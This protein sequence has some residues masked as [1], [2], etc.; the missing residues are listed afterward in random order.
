MKSPMCIVLLN[1][2]FLAAVLSSAAAA[3]QAP[4]KMRI[5]GE[6]LVLAGTQPGKLMFADVVPGS[7]VI[8]S[9][10]Q[11]GKDV[12][13]YEQGRDYVVNYALGTI[14]R[15][16]ASRMPD[17]S[18]NMLYGQKNFD[19]SKFPGFGNHAF[20]V[21]VDYE[22]R[23]GR[24]LATPMDQSPLLVKTRAKLSAGGPFKLIA[25][26]D[27]ISTGC[28]ASTED[29][30]FQHRYARALKKR[31]PKA[32]ITVENGAT[33]GDTTANGLERLDEKVLTRKPD[34]VL[35]AFG[36]NDH[37]VPAFGVALDKFEANLSQIVNTIRD[38]TGA[39]VILLSTFPPNPDWAFGS[40]QMEKYAKATRRVAEKDKC[41]YADVYSVWAVALNR[42]D[43]PS[44]LGNNINHPNDFGHWLYLQALDA[45]GF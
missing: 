27:S 37:N 7:V 24:A 23:A 12:I 18:K 34:L 14:A 41:A 9:S 15:A 30:N 5:T 42:K 33:G 45:V 43:A 28:E 26:G 22:T 10:C 1:C 2:L 6:S 13:V 29:L 44:L 3:K 36:M 19:H 17:F 40:H 11:P 32:E 16:P 38:R 20:F 39:E 25:F 35:V 4:K 31:F 21:W 8:G